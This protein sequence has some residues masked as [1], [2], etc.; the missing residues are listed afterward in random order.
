MRI[1][2]AVMCLTLLSGYAFGQS[3]RSDSASSE[4]VGPCIAN[5]RWTNTNANLTYS[6][7]SQ[8]PVSIS[9]LTHVSKGRRCSSAEI[10]VTATF[11]SDAQEFIC[12]GTIQQAMTTSSEAQT[13]NLEI[14]PFTQNDFLRWIN[15]PGNRGVQ[16]GKRL[17]CMSPD[18][19]AEIGDI[20]RI[21]ANWIHVALA[22]LPDGGGLAVLE[23]LIQA[24]P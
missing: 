8:T 24:N 21:K 19:T 14:R 3:D 1:V 6:K 20:N 16:Q 17:N 4:V 12:S 18:G 2:A 15:Q 23:A 13:F 7:Q 11:L 10:R 5:A 22:V 9:L